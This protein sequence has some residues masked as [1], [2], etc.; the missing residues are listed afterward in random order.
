M[1]WSYLLFFRGKN[2]VD[3]EAV[4]IMSILTHLEQVQP[5]L[6][7]MTI[8]LKSLQITVGNYLKT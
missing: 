7:V 8:K 6:D 3:L 1:T 5:R 2:V 4:L